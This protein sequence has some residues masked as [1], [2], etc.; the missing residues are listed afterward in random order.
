L[1]VR[2]NSDL[3]HI[4][5][6]HTGY[7]SD[8][9]G[10]FIN[11][12][13]SKQK[14]FGIP[15]DVVINTNGSIDLS[16]RWIF[17]NNPKSY[18]EDVSPLSIFRYLKHS[19]GGIGTKTNRKEAFHVGVVGDFNNSVPSSYQFNA[20][21]EVIR[22]YVCNTGNLAETSLKYYSDISKEQS[23]GVLFFKKASLYVKCREDT[24]D[25]PGWRRLVWTPEPEVEKKGWGLDYG[26]R[27][28]Y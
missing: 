2:L 18:V 4:V 20:L 6:Y 21:L 10:A 22:V 15:F 5:I 19:Y 16:A 28:K 12:V 3:K 14:S 25:T 7:S 27:Y 13:Y 1:S 24:D 11:N 17:S 9:D 26:N 8:R 23:P